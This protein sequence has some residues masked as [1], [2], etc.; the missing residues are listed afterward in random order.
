MPVVG[1]LVVNLKAQ[2]ASFTDSMG[3]TRQTFADFGEDAKT[4][5]RAVDFSMRD[6]R[7]SMMLL[8]EECGVRIPREL[9]TLI[10]ELPG[11]GA[12][13]AALVPIVGAVF[14]VGMVYKWV[15]AHKEMA[16]KAAGG[17]RDIE[18]EG[19]AA[20]SS[21]ITK[22]LELQKVADELTG[23]HI[24]ALHDE[25]EVIDRQ[26][27]SNVITEFDKLSKKADETFSHLKVGWLMSRLDAGANDAGVQNVAERFANLTKVVDSYKLA[28]N[29]TGVVAALQE[30]KD[31]VEGIITTF[32]KWGTGSKAILDANKDENGVLAEMLDYYKQLA[33]NADQLKTNTQ[34]AFD[35]NSARDSARAAET[36][37]DEIQRKRIEYQDAVMK[38]N[39]EEAKDAEKLYKTIEERNAECADQKIK[40]AELQEKLDDQTL[41]AAEKVAK[42]QYKIDEE[43]SRHSLAMHQQTA[44]QAEAAATAASK[45]ET[46][47]EVTA[48]DTRIAAL[49]RYSKDY[50]TKLKELEDKKKE[51]V[52]QGEAQVAQIRNKSQERQ[53]ADI[54]KAEQHMADAVSKSLSKTIF[55]HKSMAA[56]FE[57]M[58]AQVAESAMENAIKMILTNNM[59]KASDAGAAAAHTY[60]TISAIPVVGPFLA[61]PAAAVHTRRLWLS[62]AVARCPAMD[63]GT[64]FPPC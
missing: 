21:L 33:D 34:T 58:G 38:M 3:K 15:E 1:E 52:Q 7:G 10:A 45:A 59:T 14:A 43:A 29:S 57:Q 60:N 40:L 28:G 4:A 19:T 36:L 8:G 49:S 63:L 51:I 26:T 47:A 46:A 42:E 20:M 17:W 44:Q 13:F 61:P 55:E 9:R 32:E 16:A 5:G 23:N 30:E 54:T 22:S 62:R 31:K 50:E 11:V 12:A 53:L 35:K 37:F 41:T 6:A 27:L 2:T 24:K 39:E 18:N 25:F 56:S 64:P 48:Y